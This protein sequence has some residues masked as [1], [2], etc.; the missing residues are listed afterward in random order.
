MMQHINQTNTLIRKINKKMGIETKFEGAEHPD[1]VQNNKAE[2]LS[3]T[4]PKYNP[5]SWY[6]RALHVVR[7]FISIITI[8]AFASGA[9]AGGVELKVKD[10]KAGSATRIGKHIMVG[11]DGK[12]E[13]ATSAGTGFSGGRYIRGGDDDDPPKKYNFKTAQDYIHAADKAY[14]SD[15]YNEAWNIIDESLSRINQKTLSAK[16]SELD[17]LNHIK[18]LAYD[19]MNR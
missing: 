11:P 18:E 7:T 9:H 15:N 8:G 5:G 16:N 1:F 10:G 17:D 12:I 6:K 4:R 3:S 13:S 2:E 14:Q 19:H